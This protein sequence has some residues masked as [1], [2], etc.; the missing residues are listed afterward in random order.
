MLKT[1]AKTIILEIDSAHLGRGR[2][3]YVIRA[4]C[5]HDGPTNSEYTMIAWDLDQF[6]IDPRRA[7]TK[8]FL[9]SHILLW[10]PI[11]GKSVA[12]VLNRLREDLRL[13]LGED[14][15]MRIR[16]FEVIKIIDIDLRNRID[17][18]PLRNRVEIVIETGLPLSY[19]TRAYQLQSF[20][21]TPTFPVDDSDY[22]VSSNFFVVDEASSLHGLSA[23]NL[24]E[25][26]DMIREFG[27]GRS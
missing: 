13:I 10:E 18:G 3:P 14:G 1:L 2:S 16:E 7:A 8:I 23:A 15:E 5:F 17:D 27:S 22:E 6:E 26:V 19:R 20:R 21:L 4:E 12:E 11:R 24:D 9:E 25:L